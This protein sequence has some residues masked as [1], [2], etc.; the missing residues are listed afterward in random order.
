MLVFISL[1]QQIQIKAIAKKV[2]TSA[3]IW[4]DVDERK[5]E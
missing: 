2:P 1:G 3:R 5:K 4:K